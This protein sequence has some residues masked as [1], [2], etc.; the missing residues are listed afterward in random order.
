MLVASVCRSYYTQEKWCFVSRH[1]M[2]AIRTEVLTTSHTKDGSR[3]V[4]LWRKI[5]TCDFFPRCLLKDERHRW[6]AHE[7][8]EHSFIKT[9]LSSHPS[10]TRATEQ[11]QT[12]AK[13]EGKVWYTTELTSLSNHSGYKHRPRK[14]VRYGTPLNSHSSPTRAAE[15]KQTQAKKEGKVWYTTELTSLSKLT[16]YRPFFS[17]ASQRN[18]FGLVWMGLHCFIV[19]R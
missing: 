3:L 7:L 15:Q 19:Y 6:S 5:M 8:M 1:N 17:V 11:K 2:V 13:K 14:K 18:R 9:P 12:Q 10:P 16:A 4:N